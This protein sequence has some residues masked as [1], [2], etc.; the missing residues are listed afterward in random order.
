MHIVRIDLVALLFLF[1]LN[2][3]IIILINLRLKLFQYFFYLR[4]AF[5]CVSHDLLVNKLMVDFNLEPKYVKLIYE[6]LTNRVFK[7]HGND[8]LYTLPCGIPQGSALGPLLFSI[9]IN[10]MGESISCPFLT[11]ADDLVIY[12][13]GTNS[14]DV[15]KSLQKDVI[16]INVWC[17]MNGL[18]INFDK[19]KYMVFHKDKDL[20]IKYECHDRLEIENNVIERVFEFKYLGLIFEPC[21]QFKKHFVAVKKRVS[22]RLS[23]LQGV[24]RF[25]STNVMTIMVNAMSILLSIMD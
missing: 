1:F 13:S 17:K 25:L 12:Q 9:F 14:S 16:A 23:Y 7:I 22:Q 20:S 4:S 15:L 6:G 24:K 10:K 11:Y 18:K 8:K 21:M 19:T 2:L 5:D 3:Y